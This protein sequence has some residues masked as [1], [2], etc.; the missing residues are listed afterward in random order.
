M[1]TEI[2]SE[3]CS[4]KIYNHARKSKQQRLHFE[5][6]GEGCADGTFPFE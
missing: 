2:D 5:T 4:C 6:I 1:P 3:I